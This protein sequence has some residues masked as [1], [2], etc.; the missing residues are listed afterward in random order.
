MVKKKPSIN[1]KY[2]LLSIGT[3]KNKSL[4]LPYIQKASENKKLIFYATEKTH[5]YL[6]DHAAPTTL[7]YKIS[8]KNKTPNIAELLEQKVFDIIINIPTT[9]EKDSKEM[10]DGRL[11]RKR[12]IELDI[13]LVT[14]IDV[15]SMILDKVAKQ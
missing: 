14:D 13:N 1:K 10:T 7:V 6:K 15:A 9:R 8:Q 12:S 5:R 11:I 4:L 3:L 2:I